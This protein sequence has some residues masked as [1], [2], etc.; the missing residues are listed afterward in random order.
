MQ[1]SNF[2]DIQIK[3]D[4]LYSSS[5]KCPRGFR[6]KQPP[7]VQ[8]LSGSGDLNGK[9][10]GLLDYNP[11]FEKKINKNFDKFNK[12][13]KISISKNTNINY[14]KGLR[15]LEIDGKKYATYYLPKE[16]IEN[17]REKS[18]G[19][20]FLLETN[21]IY[22]IGISFIELYLNLKQMPDELL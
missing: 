9:I 17:A 14:N 5:K 11:K 22:Y 15:Y 12:L 19:F 6:E 3:L 1:I 20:H 2:I 18:A 10:V 8:V 4:K 16:F 21:G 7:F 13:E